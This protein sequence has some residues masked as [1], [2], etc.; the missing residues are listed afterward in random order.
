M[1]S[2][3]RQKD[4]KTKVS[5]LDFFD[6]NLFDPP[7]KYVSSADQTRSWPRKFQRIDNLWQW[8]KADPPLFL[9]GIRPYV[10]PSISVILSSFTLP[11]RRPGNYDVRRGIGEAN[12]RTLEEASTVITSSSSFPRSPS[13]GGGET[14]GR[15]GE[16]G[17]P[18]VRS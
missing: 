15:R 8:L 10:H 1:D 4:N 11:L 18:P 5:L 12:E 6:E 7:K 13:V 14:Q 2:K 9:S 17:T 16:G 3:H